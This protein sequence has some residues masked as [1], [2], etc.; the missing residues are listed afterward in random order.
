MKKLLFFVFIWTLFLSIQAQETRDFRTV[1]NGFGPSRTIERTPSNITPAEIQFW[2]G[3]GT[4]EMIAVFYWCQDS[5][6]GLAYGYRWDGTKTIGNM[7]QEIDA[8]DPR[9][10]FNITTWI[11]FYSY[12]DNTF[13]LSIA[14]AGMLSY[15]VNGVWANG[16]TD[17]LSNN[18]LFEMEEY[19]NCSTPTNVIPVTDPNGPQLPDDET[20]SLNEIE[21]WVGGGPNRVV[22]TVNW[23]DTA[24]AFAWGINFSG[25]SILV[26][27]IMN[28]VALY[29]PRIT[30]SY[31]DWGINDIT[32]QDANYNLSLSGD[33]WMYNVNGITA[34]QGIS[35]QYV[36]NGDLI[37]WGDESC[38][39]SDE[40]FNYV[41]ITPIQ[42]IPKGE[43]DPIFY[44]GI[45][46]SQ[47]FKSISY[48]N[49]SILAWASDCQITRGYQDIANPVV[50]A[51]YGDPQNAVGPASNST[52]EVVSLGD[53]GS[54]V[55]SF[56]TPIMNGVG[57]DFAV[58]ENSLND[59]FLELAFVEVSS[60]G[61]HFFR[62][63]SVSNTPNQVQVSNS[64]SLDARFIHN[65]AGKH[66]AG[67]GTMFD[68]EELNGYYGLNITNVTHI[69]IVDVVGS[70]NP[71]FGTTDRYG[72]I[73][74]DPYPTDFAS[75]GFDLGGV[76]VLNGYIP[77]TI[78][79]YNT[80]LAID[81]YP[82]PC[83]DYVMIENQEGKQAALYNALGQMVMNQSIEN[84]N[85]KMEMSHLK[86]GIYFLQIDNQTVKIIKK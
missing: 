86:S 62:F 58:F 57:Y 15:T 35:Q 73:I 66:R 61:I 48:D 50:L 2:V 39:I 72:K 25:D 82:N 70:I 63:P 14:S 37:K 67:W 7:L 24:I 55:L 19:G 32:Y 69:R 65:L 74:N 40:N 52:T 84:S 27:D 18:D 16:L 28:T 8:A 64:G 4:N 6:V 44:D 31:G 3:S 23:C 41:W 54:A 75:G 71:L 20:I 13:N 80:G 46:G 77:E 76:A 36:K 11:N 17:L 1:Q 22:L 26:A 33:W 5:A 34:L 51:S 43:A 10:S 68:L 85:E 56:S 29:D 38:G 12:L 47:N 45:V 49:S 81:I 79:D 9:I 59:I 60:D 78:D 21:Y 83:T 30:F 53:N 42:P